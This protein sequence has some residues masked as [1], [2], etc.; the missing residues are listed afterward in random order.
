V[1]V[2]RREALYE[3]VDP[4]LEQLSV[5]QKFM[6]RVGPDNAA[7]L[8]STLRVLRES[9]AARTAPETALPR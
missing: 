6:I 2:V 8:K 7:T 4:N 5:G 9:I 1:L 3:F